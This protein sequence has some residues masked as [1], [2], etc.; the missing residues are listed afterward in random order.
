MSK[1][2]ALID[3]EARG[4]QDE[5]IITTN[6]DK[7]LFNYQWKKHTN[8]S[9]GSVNIDYKG[10][11]N[12]GS[13]IKFQIPNNDG[14][15]LT[16][17]FFNVQVPR[18]GV[19]L[20]K[21]KTL[22]KSLYKVKWTDYLGNV[23]IEKIIFR[24]NGQIITEQSGTFIEIQTEFFDEDW[25]RKFMTGQNDTLTTPSDEILSE[26]LF[27]PLKFWFTNDPDK[28]LP[29]KSLQRS[30]LEIEIK[31]RQFDECYQVLKE[32]T[33]I[34]NPN[35]TFYVYTKEKLRKINL[36]KLSME[37]I[38]VYLDAEERLKLSNENIRQE[39]LITQVQERVLPITHDDKIDLNFNHP[40]KELFFTL[41]SNEVRHDNELFNFSNKT[42]FIPSKYKNITHVDVK[43]FQQLPKYHLLDSARI[44]FNNI[45]RISW[46]NYKYFFYLQNYE[47]FRVYPEN[48]VYIF[49]FSMNPSSDN[50]TG[51]CNFSRLDSAE[52]QFRK[53]NIPIK[54]I[55]S[56]TGNIQINGSIN[57]ENPGII[58][59]YAINY[60][61]LVIENGIATLKFK[62]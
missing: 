50:P 19:D 56:N 2:G 29:L 12:W 58:T 60:N 33:D 7:T 57:I 49:S 35:D 25:S 41:Q 23:I 16:S 30:H 52:L 59:V 36:D 62:I 15:L 61:I 53:S 10:S 38:Y 37:I 6:I 18:I 54:N 17:V 27:M 13:S 4:E 8:F 40:V 28:A 47:H 24:I 42:N 21:N 45:E 51:S 11:G 34:N 43:R 14:D 39:I 32:I 3:I 26:E 20:L 44:I 48:Y 46:K 5:D 9:R 55:N 1:N 22:D 31:L